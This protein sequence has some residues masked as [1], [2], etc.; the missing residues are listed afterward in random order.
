MDILKQV[1]HLLFG[2]TKSQQGNNY[3]KIETTY[4]R[5]LLALDSL[6]E[7]SLLFAS[8]QIRAIEDMVHEDVVIFQNIW[9]VTNQEQ[10]Q[11]SF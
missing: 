4:E 10:G 6:S 7:M 5:F 11:C 3:K 1:K 2:G 9:E 8:V